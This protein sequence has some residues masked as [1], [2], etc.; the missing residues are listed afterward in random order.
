MKKRLLSAVIA[1]AMCIG[2][3]PPA[4][5]L[6][7]EP[8]IVDQPQSASYNIGD[9]P[10]ALSVSVEMEDSCELEF[11]WYSNTLDSTDDGE[12]LWDETKEAVAGETIT[13]Y[14]TPPTDVRGTTYYYCEVKVQDTDSAIISDIAEIT[15]NDS[16]WT[17]Y[18]ANSYAG[19]D[20]SIDNPYQ[21]ATAEQ[22]AML[23]KEMNESSTQYSGMH[24]QLTQDIDLS[25]HR[26]IP[27]GMTDWSGPGSSISF[28]GYFDGNNK[29]ITGLFVDESE[30]GHHAGLFGSIAVTKENNNEGV[31]VKDLVIEDANIISSNASDT[32]NA[33]ASYAGILVGCVLANYGCVGSI[34]NVQVSGSINMTYH[35]GGFVG[36]SSNVGY[37]EC[38][39]DVQITSGEVTG[40]FVGEAQGGS[41]TNCIS[42]GSIS[43]T[44]S[45][46][47][48][49]GEM[50]WN[51]YDGLK[52]P[53]IDHCAAYVDV[54][55]SDCNTGGFAGWSTSE[56]ESTISNCAAFG[57]VENLADLEPKTG[58]FIGTCSATTTITKSHFAGVVTSS[59]MDI[60]SGGFVGLDE[61][62]NT[63][64]C[65]F[66]STKNP[67]KEAVGNT[68]I[69]GSHDITALPTNDVLFEICEDYY[70][71]HNYVS[72]YCSRCQCRK[73]YATWIEAGMDALDG[74]DYSVDSEGNYTVYTALGL[75][76]IA[77]LSNGT[78]G[79]TATVFKDKTV[80]LGNNIYLTEANV[81]GYGKD[82]VTSA[83]SWNPIGSSTQV[84]S[85]TFDGNGYKINGLYIENSENNQGLFGYIGT[86][87]TIKNLMIE[88]GYV[89]AKINVGAFTGAN[90]GG[91]I[92]DCVN[93]DCTIY[94]ETALG[95]IVGTFSGG[96]IKRCIN[97]SDITNDANK[98]DAYLGGIAGNAGN[99]AVVENCRNNGKISSDSI[100]TYCG[101]I[102]GVN[103]ST[104]ISCVND[105][106]VYASGEET[107]IGG[108]AGIN[109]NLITS[110]I[111]SAA[112]TGDN[113]VL[114]GGILGGSWE[115]D[116]EVNNC[117]NTGAV[118]CEDYMAGGIIG[119]LY[120]GN[121]K[122]CYNI[123]DITGDFD[124]GVIGYND[125]GT[126]QNTFFLKG[127][128]SYGSRGNDDDEIIVAE[129]ISETE[130]NE[131]GIT[132][133]LQSNQTAD[134]S[135][136]IPQ[137]WGQALI[138]TEIDAYPV[139]SSD[140]VKNVCKVT[141]MADG[142]EFAA[143]YTNPN[144]TVTL[145]ENNP[146]AKDGNGFGYWT[147]STE[148]SFPADVKVDEFTADTVVFGDI[149][150]YPVWGR[151]FQ[152][153]AGTANVY[154]VAGGTAI[155]DLN[156]CIEF[157]KGDISKD[158][159]FT[160]E[161]SGTL[162]E[163][164]TF[165][166][167]STVTWSPSDGTQGPVT[168][169]F[170]VTDKAPFVSLM[171]L[172]PDPAVQTATLT[173]Q[174]IVTED[175]SQEYGFKKDPSDT[176]GNTYLISDSE[177]MN[178]LQAY[179]NSGHNAD[180]LTFIMTNDIDLGGEEKPWT[181][182]GPATAQTIFK[183]T[184]DGKG[185]K[186]SGLYIN[187]SDSYQ[188]L[189][190]Y[191]AAGGT[192]KKV[193]V[194]GTVSGADN[195]G[196]VAGANAGTI[197]N[198]YSTCTIT[199]NGDS[200]GGIVGNNAGTIENCYNTGNIFTHNDEGAK[201][202]YAGGIT[203]VGRGVI[204]NCYNTGDVM[205]DQFAGG[206]LGALA[207]ELENCYNIGTISTAVGNRLGGI[208]GNLSSGYSM[209]NCFYLTDSAQ[210]AHN[211][212]GTEINAE[213][214]VLQA[215]FTN[216]D[217]D[218]VWEMDEWLA[219]PV[220]R[221][222]R[223]DDGSGTA[224]DPY[225]IPDLETLERFRDMVNAGND[226]NGK[227]IILTNDIV[228]NP[229]VF[230]ENGGYT[231]ADSES[232]EQWEPIGSAKDNPFLGTL[233]G[234]GHTISGLYINAP[235]MDYQGLF[236]Y[237]GDDTAEG[238]EVKN[239]GVVNSFIKGK[240]AVGCIAGISYGTLSNIYTTGTVVGSSA[241]GGIIGDNA[242]T[243]QNS[244]IAGMVTG[245][246]AVG[247][248][249]GSNAGTV[250]NCYY[251]SEIFTGV[252]TTAG[253]TGKTTSEFASGEV[254]HMLQGAQQEQVWGQMIIGEKTD[255][256]PVLSNDNTKKVLKVTFIANSVEYAVSYTNMNGTVTL[257]Q[258]PVDE[259]YDFVKWSQ[260]NS[261]DGEEFIESTVVTSDMTV[262][263][264]GQEMFG[265][266]G[267]DKTI[268]AVYGDGAIQDLSYY[269]VYAAGTEAA[270][271]FNYEIIGG[272]KDTA[273]TNG[274]TVAATIEDDMLIVPDDT[275]SDTYTLDIKATEKQPE[276][277]VMSFDLGTAPVEFTVTV[278]IN[279]KT[280]T[281]SD[282]TFT[283]SSD[284]VYDGGEKVAA[285]TVNDSIA[286]AEAVTVKYYDI[287]GTQLNSA[288]VDIGTY[289]VK[290]D[291][292]E[293]D[294]FNAVTDLTDNAWKFTIV[295]SGTEFEN[296]AATDKASYIYGE[297]IT[298]TAKPVPTGTEASLLSLEPPAEN[299]MAVFYEDTQ[300]SE[301][302][303]A[304]EDGVYIMTV[305]SK[306]IGI[307][308]SAMLT[309]KYVGNDN[310]ADYSENLIVVINKATLSA[311]D[312]TFI[313]MSENELVYDGS[314]KT[315]LVT[316]KDDI[317][318]AGVVTVKYY[319]EDG[320][321][322]ESAPTDAG[323]YI[324]KVDVTEGDNYNETIDLTD[325]SWTFEVR[326]AAA[327]IAESGT[328]NAGRVKLGQKL[329]TS[330]ITRGV[331]N[332]L[333]NEPLEGTW[334]WKNDRVMDE[335]G[336]FEETAVFT[337]DDKN[338][339]PIETVLS[340]T[341]YRASSGGGGGSVTVSYT[342][343]FDTQ[344]GSEVASK[345]VTSG[346]SAAKPEDP[347]KDGYVFEGWFT[348]KACTEAYD[349]D[350]KVTKNIT[351]YAKW[352]EETTQTPEPTETTEPT[353]PDE[354]E[355]PFD[356]VE[357]DDWFYED[358]KFTQE[359]GLFSGMSETE[360][361]PD[362]AIT[363][364]MLVTVL[365]RA[366]NQPVVNYLMSFEDVDEAAYY[367]EAIRWAASEKI[368]NGYSE[369]EFA[370]DKL[371]TREEMAAIINR[372]A[373]YK[374]ME[375]AQT[376]DLSQ[377]TDAAQ[378]SEWASANVSWAVGNGILSGRGDGTLDPKGNTTRA[379][380]AAILH[381][382]IEKQ[383]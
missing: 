131:G 268:T 236:G 57:N 184:F 201:S 13:S 123:G 368:V 197:E 7:E 141:F 235:D 173:L 232:A 284:L 333:N 74:E 310:M 282:F 277:S 124:G 313:A 305:D 148:S 274:N 152:Q 202:Q 118:T 224:E 345:S 189:F 339:A 369:T 84:F 157:V 181:P 8:N 291:V 272:N 241:V 90:N 338:Y 257:P 146:P 240:D 207:G 96:S 298:V 192:V 200:V 18:A 227:Y 109:H 79:E 198:C 246:D 296:G 170:T 172:D 254:A 379:E 33:Y 2:L 111:N 4:V 218:N 91:T 323:K 149:N 26:W 51:G 280:L 167:N 346:N 42:K 71:G 308:D 16:V 67:D 69:A 106:E 286:G 375:T 175:L 127:T 32:G 76:K 122:N 19:G 304:N 35:S 196:G 309:V 120:K 48:F 382:L 212:Y 337:P 315:V 164:V 59:Y 135:G 178:R 64:E 139:L 380:T 350:S 11:T 155:I 195:V 328:P 261:A 25:G 234:N 213:D 133:R 206:I 168:V 28:S 140:S 347:T 126:A 252:D 214:F 366:E 263:A 225:M 242:G 203:G 230:D 238:A 278:I 318:G 243:V 373:D 50:A 125:S 342:V 40:G 332:G 78:G 233:D 100:Y 81:A 9:T 68:L 231:P 300:V 222:P 289:T 153:T 358:I 112:I 117:Y 262:Y 61:G 12:Y 75:A 292:A 275:N 97:L 166:N 99:N 365:W 364:G 301:A 216:W 20:G 353:E 44:R 65:S 63:I 113:T 186:I 283:P 88:S 95:G 87:S 53:S 179:V 80:T 351:L 72:N 86:D 6:A 248:I 281:V 93:N 158:G 205:A 94:G 327:V 39:A 145:P 14:Y 10:E 294:N 357:E 194:S 154:A 229:G 52:G 372:Y 361:A 344:G 110:C 220:L 1:A 367:G 228:I 107:Y 55:A 371:I 279:K 293:N 165:D 378:I 215:E 102:V 54:T 56:T 237:L 193:G 349:F 217:F 188:G 62:G 311:D 329:S 270:G 73:Q 27:I 34:E 295:K 348:D 269:M 60:P 324:V 312:F 161:L 276:F 37:K 251:N 362:M 247:S 317:T 147:T 343:T 23:A 253:V 352:T 208:V 103:N 49:V 183:G 144:G 101:G 169:S 191:V 265:E 264:V 255:P 285:V 299:Q 137:V 322:L 187:A 306:L 185:F 204:K 92:E 319:S 335:T 244:Y 130:F 330:N 245:S 376:G 108:I 174:F 119:Y 307:N 5:I 374:G 58:G 326:Q 176:S 159:Q 128:A 77:N 288:P 105:G 3:F 177:D 17:D 316:L 129:K 85:G 70:N 163:G 104:I 221:D 239:I 354:W 24:F 331:V 370:P 360:F 66:D 143:K 45:T 115:S 320:T 29:K 132:Y 114:A 359:K 43:G 82:T 377:F 134:G 267:D 287:N 226:Y 36:F 22:L 334:T 171:G 89:H 31:V 46:G 180:G 138:G 21:I 336:T 303:D 250:Q 314:E 249:I 297:I 266:T 341:V 83:N 259:V 142:T 356:D 30:K 290:I 381:R 271:K 190:G 211:N 210:G 151:Q 182:I 121:V 258:D 223:E 98:S 162:P 302:A 260:E 150:V 160:F 355:N 209:K 47:G 156:D 340:V 116:T 219:R 383:S 325:A 321:Q 41:F 273:T 199:S 38:T 363:R 136:K 256:T 15:V